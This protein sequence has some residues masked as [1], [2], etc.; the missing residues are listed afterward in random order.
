MTTP[1]PAPKLVAS[2]V[3]GTLIDSAERVP[4]RLREVITRMTAQGTAMALSTGRPARWIYTVLEQL[5]VRPVCVCANGAVIYDSATDRILKAHT[6]AP[7]TMVEV[8]ALAEAAMA[9]HGGVSFAVERAGRSAFD[10]VD[11]LFLVTPEYSHAWPTLD[12]HGVVP[13]TTLISEPATK[14]L[15]RSDFLE[16]KEMFDRLRPVIPEEVGHVTFSMSGGLLEVAAPGVTKALGVSY[17]AELLGV[18]QEDVITFGDMPNDIEMLQWAGRGV[19]M[20]N[21]RPEVKA[22]SDF[23]TA[24]ND[25]A[26]VAD[27][28]EWWF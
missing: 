21:A 14:L 3:D 5:P 6:L 12:D 19:A 25:E 20:G 24:T 22:V 13:I 16:S 17:L 4:A 1:G 10:N 28:L 15:L 23:V 7:E 8:V 26:G 18:A 27:V 9:D 11:E 2:D